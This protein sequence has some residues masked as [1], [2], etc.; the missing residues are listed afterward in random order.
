M[1]IV[2]VILTPTFRAERWKPTAD[3]N[4]SYVAHQTE[5]LRCILRQLRG[6]AFPIPFP[7]SPHQ[8]AAFN[9]L[10]TVLEDRTSSEPARISAVQNALWAISSEPA[11]VAWGNMHQVYFGFLALRMDGCY[12]DAAAL[13]PHL[14]KFEY[15]IR[16]TCLYSA[17]HLPVDEAIG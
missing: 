14:A 8:R 16:M 5:F 9:Q 13:T 2:L 4:N 7:L 6:H 11:T 17:V 1:P 15:M 12:A 10:S 3:H